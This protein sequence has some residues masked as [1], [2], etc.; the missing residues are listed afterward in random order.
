MEG[1]PSPSS[2]AAGPRHTFSAKWS[3]QESSEM[4]CLEISMYKGQPHSVPQLHSTA[5]RSNVAGPLVVPKSQSHWWWA[6]P[7]EGHEKRALVSSPRHKPVLVLTSESLQ[8]RSHSPCPGICLS[9]IPFFSQCTSCWELRCLVHAS[10]PQGGLQGRPQ[11]EPSFCKECAL[12]RAQDLP[13]GH[14]SAQAHRPSNPA[15]LC[16]QAPGS[17]TARW[18][19]SCLFLA[20]MV[21]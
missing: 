12:G 10:S 7:R 19:F 13:T 6:R 5:S 17:P 18:V 14:T 4:L 16:R 3:R 8:N 1:K 15:G 21:S 9:L 20:L 11:P 2:S